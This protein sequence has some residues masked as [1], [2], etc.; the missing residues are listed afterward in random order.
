[1]STP[2]ALGY[3]MPAEWEPHTATWFSWPR[4][5]CI[6]FR[7]HMD[8]VWLAFAEM[9]RVISLHEPVHIN[10]TDA[11]MQAEV[12]SF[13][14][15]RNVTRAGIQ[16]HHIPTN[17]PWC[18]D[19]GPTF[20]KRG[21]EFALVDWDYNAYGGK[22]RPFDRD[23]AVPQLIA[24]QLGC[25]SFRPGIVLEG[26]SIDVNGAGAVLVTEAC[27]LHPN[28]N[29]KLT[30]AGIEER[31]RE[32]LGVNDVLWLG[33][34]LAGDD[35]DGHV[36]DLTRFVSTETVVTAV[37]PDSQDANHAA[38]QDNLRRLR[39]MPA[40][41]RIVELPMPAPVVCRGE[42]QPAS[43]ANFYIANGLV[44]VPTFGD[45]NDIRALAILRDLFPNRRV[46]G[47][48]SRALIC[49]GGSFHCLTQQQPA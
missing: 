15:G 10:V 2:R 4:Q 28:R 8:D 6:S 26:G 21:S 34:G 27:L 42:R 9:A 43:Y 46:L 17:E 12:T 29:P 44:L 11:E 31:L 25:P 38:L 20:L 45:P 32:F 1:V 7:T 33:N 5:Q 19:H 30:R 3:R 39:A 49:G 16:F 18:R 23:D 41:K 40:I 22:F 35:T 36:D 47:L 24:G 37:E 48:D 14:A 13:L